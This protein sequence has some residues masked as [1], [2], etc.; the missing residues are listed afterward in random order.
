MPEIWPMAANYNW[1]KK[2]IKLPTINNNNT[3]SWYIL[4]WEYSMLLVVITA[5]GKKVNN[6][7]ALFFSGENKKT[8]Q[9]IKNPKTIFLYE[10]CKING[11]LVNVKIIDSRKY[12]E[13][14]T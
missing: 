14:T 2:A 9:P 7:I 10:A 11:L 6:N 8:T 3:I 12:K 4:F 13:T 5:K 1:A